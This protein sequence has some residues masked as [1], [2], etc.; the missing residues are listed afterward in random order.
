MNLE[1][2]TSLLPN[3]Q[4]TGF[5]VCPRCGKDK[6]NFLLLK[7]RTK[8]ACC[9]R[10]L[11][12]EC[13]YSVESTTKKEIRLC[14]ACYYPYQ[15]NKGKISQLKPHIPCLPKIVQPFLSDE[16]MTR[17]VAFKEFSKL[18][19]NNGVD[20]EFIVKS[21]LIPYMIKPLQDLN[22][23]L[24][25]SEIIK[26][27]LKRNI[28]LKTFFDKDGFSYL[29]KA[30]NY[31]DS[32]EFLSNATFI[33]SEIMMSCLKN[34]LFK[35]HETIKEMKDAL[36]MVKNEYE[37][38]Y[39]VFWC[40]REN[41][42]GKYVSMLQHDFINETNLL[43]ICKLYQKGNED[44]KEVL[45]LSFSIFK[46][47]FKT[48]SFDVTKDCLQEVMKCFDCISCMIVL[49]LLLEMIT[50][51]SLMEIAINL[52]L[53]EKI[54][55]VLKFVQTE[56][57]AD[58]VDVVLARISDNDKF[59]NH[60]LSN[61]DLFSE[62]LK[63]EKGN[64]TV[65][66]KLIESI[67]TYKGVDG[68]TT[69]ELILTEHIDLVEL[70]LN[71]GSRE[72]RDQGVIVLDYLIQIHGTE[73]FEILEARGILNTILELCRLN[74]CQ[75]LLLYIAL[76][77]IYFH[78]EI[79]ELFV[80]FL[81]D[82]DFICF[83][84]IA[85][86]NKQ[87]IHQSLPF[88][89]QLASNKRIQQ[90]I[91]ERH[92][93][94]FNRLMVLFNE[95]NLSDFLTFQLLTALTNNSR[96]A[97]ILIRNILNQ[98]G[99]LSQIMQFHHAKVPLEYVFP[100]I[101]NLFQTHCKDQVFLSC[102]L[103][104]FISFIKYFPTINESALVPFIELCGAICNHSRYLR[105][106]FVSTAYGSETLFQ[107]IMKMLASNNFNIKVAVM[108]L[109]ISF[110]ENGHDYSVLIKSNPSLF[111]ELFKGIENLPDQ[112]FTAISFDFVRTCLLHK[113][114]IESF[115]RSRIFVILLMVFNPNSLPTI[116][117]ELLKSSLELLITIFEIGISSIDYS[118]IVP[119]LFY[120][121]G[122]VRFNGITNTTILYL[123]RTLIFLN[124]PLIKAVDKTNVISVLCNLI[125]DK[126]C[127]DYATELMKVLMKEKELFI[128]SLN[129]EIFQQLLQKSFIN[130][131][132]YSLVIDQINTN[133]TIKPTLLKLLSNTI[134]EDILFLT[135]TKNIP[136][137]LQLVN[138]IPLLSTIN[139]TQFIKSCIHYL[140]N[141]NTKDINNFISFLQKLKPQE[142]ESLTLNVSFNTFLLQILQ[143][144]DDCIL[145][146]FELIKQSAQCIDFIYSLIPSFEGIIQFILQKC[147][148]FEVIIPFL[149][150]ADC[151][152][153]VTSNTFL[154][155]ILFEHIKDNTSC[156][157]ILN[158]LLIDQ[159]FIPMM[160]LSVDIRSLINSKDK[161]VQEEILNI[162][163][164]GSKHDGMYLTIDFIE[165]M[166]IFINSD[167]SLY[168]IYL[169][170][171][172]HHLQ[173]QNITLILTKEV[174]INILE[175]GLKERDDE[176]MN[177]IVSLCQ[178]QQ[179]SDYLGI[180]EAREII[181]LISKKRTENL[182]ENYLSSLLTLFSI[183]S[184]KLSNQEIIDLIHKYNKNTVILLK[185]KSAFILQ[186]LL[187]II[188]M[189]PEEFIS[190]T[191]KQYIENIV[192]VC[193]ENPTNNILR[194]NVVKYLSLL[195]NSDDKVDVI[196]EVK[197]TIG[198]NHLITIETK[199]QIERIVQKI[200]QN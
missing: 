22:S 136:K 103:S 150:F 12:S 144:S 166:R 95:D 52:S 9:H 66:V 11:C 155:N 75:E 178:N 135:E 49:P 121:L 193:K 148:Y 125:D 14:F 137:V 88:F 18:W 19:N 139:L 109:A 177:S 24:L 162:L 84:C 92:C 37:E 102:A 131:L 181:S 20:Y 159:T 129:V 78:S 171:L 77:H 142:L 26:E 83:L 60:L 56:E 133:E 79:K 27:G 184:N 72:K 120:Y 32:I 115:K 175:R 124:S 176:I 16:P 156:C 186:P 128:E 62:L 67:L 185:S 161:T 89:V 153:I 198:F 113:R 31:L 127:S 53:I 154:L 38:N 82:N 40:E 68:K 30:I 74:N 141:L 130:E 107:T 91:F 4:Q 167:I 59:Y 28:E 85:I 55:N 143:Y 97:I 5:S 57:F 86:E 90:D 51:Q 58:I 96:Y 165:D 81:I 152:L 35:P 111:I 48:R 10:F 2:V 6:S 197:Q 174:I 134:I 46:Q 45:L 7:K 71:S 158:H 1:L 42:L 87:N 114:E 122:N 147:S 43:G 168:R 182:S 44:E 146:Y 151:R 94:N 36:K 73:A 188:L 173:H 118:G 145:Q 3:Q 15:T 169:H 194:I 25:L 190:Q 8:C 179:I 116:S 180:N 160:I 61:L 80:Q 123:I 140:P 104:S 29:F 108:K 191:K 132:V 172:Q 192:E 117:N 13:L 110:I 105:D 157:V 100:F 112:Q 23:S 63:C 199:E 69:T 41:T 70:M 98:E 17:Q 34:Y 93:G 76:T 170:I 189:T 187:S 64:E 163:F 200:D 54:T 50:T 39:C 33:I 101:K 196:K 65:S 149:L 138:W 195:I 164:E 106:R 21:G 119:R 126:D 99:L 183:I 47:T